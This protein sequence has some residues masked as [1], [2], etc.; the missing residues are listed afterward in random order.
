MGCCDGVGYAIA[1][2][3]G[4]PCCEKGERPFG[5]AGGC[6]CIGYDV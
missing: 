6:D 5:Y 2:W 4:V 1:A 3:I